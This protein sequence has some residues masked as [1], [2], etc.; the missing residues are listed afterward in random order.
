MLRCTAKLVLA[1]LTLHS[2][3]PTAPSTTSYSGF[4]AHYG[5]GTMAR[6]ARVRHMA[7]AACMVASHRLPLGRWVTVLGLRTGVQRHCKVVDICHPKHCASIL[8]RRVVVELS[9]QDNLT[10]CGYRN[11]PPRM[12][13]VSVVEV[14]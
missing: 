12:C 7:P 9:Y 6:V 4:A 3:T 14:R 13:P 11:E 8:R 2:T 5:P 1:A 10:I